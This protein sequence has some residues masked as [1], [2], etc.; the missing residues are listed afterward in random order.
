MLVL[1]FRLKHKTKGKRVCHESREESSY[2]CRV[3]EG[4][5]GYDL[6]HDHCSEREQS[7]LLKPLCERFI[8]FR[9]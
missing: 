8:L 9:S 6:L 3:N 7:Y 1:L 5:A 2:D 4:G